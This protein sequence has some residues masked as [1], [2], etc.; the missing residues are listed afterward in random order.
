MPS[1]RNAAKRVR[2]R[3]LA[4]EDAT[5]TRLMPLLAPIVARMARTGVGT[6]AC[7]RAGALPMPVHFYSPVPDLADLEARGVYG[8][9]SALGGVA[10][11]EP[12]QLARL[13]RLGASWGKECDWPAEPTGRPERFFTENGGF[14]FGCAAAT[15]C[16]IREHRPSRV[17]EIGSGNSS[18][19]IAAAL[20]RNGAPS[21]YTIVDPY[22]G[23]IVRGGLPGVTRVLAQRVELLDPAFFDS[24]SAGDVLFVDSGHTVRTGGDVNFLIL[25][26][27]PR[28]A[29]GVLVH[30][31]DIP[32]PDEYPRAYFTNPKFRVFWT[33]S[34]LLQAFLAFNAAYDV[35]FAMAWLMGER[36]AQFAEAF[37][38]YDR[39]RHRAMSGSLWI[40]RKPDPLAP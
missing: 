11:D 34:Y 13:A 31:H 28:L 5:Y 19:V 7:L 6:D 23:P 2:D 32:M 36:P 26:V 39:Q 3:L 9:R 27:L 16:L 25:D 38:H 29:P 4:L 18:L 24:L 10:F 30:F 35:L 1:L 8:R 22:P 14:S 33:E 21:D 40:Q 12:G 20:A 17:V 15:H 37:P